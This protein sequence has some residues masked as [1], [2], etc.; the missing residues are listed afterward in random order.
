[1]EHSSLNGAEP[2]VGRWLLWY[3]MDPVPVLPLRASLAAAM[4]GRLHPALLSAPSCQHTQQGN[5]PAG[6]YNACITSSVNVHIKCEEVL[7]W[8]FLESIRTAINPLLL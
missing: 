4:P 6:G 3:L 1:M 5:L 8:K 7:N 2:T